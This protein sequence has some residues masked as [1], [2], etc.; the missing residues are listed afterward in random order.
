MTK[1][2]LFILTDAMQKAGLT[3]KQAA[4]CVD[5]VLVTADQLERMDRLRIK[6]PDRLS[7]SLSDLRIA[8]D[9]SG[10]SIDALLYDVEQA[11]ADG[12]TVTRD[13]LVDMV[14]GDV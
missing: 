11:L 2:F 1:D 9:G 3:A 8:S 4:D 12:H 6:Y 10:R 14:R 7:L 5:A 13:L